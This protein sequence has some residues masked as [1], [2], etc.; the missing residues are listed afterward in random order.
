MSAISMTKEERIAALERF[1]YTRREASFLCIAALQGGYFMRRQFCTFLDKEMGGTAAS[2]V[3]KLLTRKHG[4]AVTAFN[5]TKIY[6]LGS[7]PFYA[8][9]GEGDNRNRRERS[10]PG[11]KSRLIGLDFVL[12]HPDYRYLATEG[13][14]LDYFV[15]TLGVPMGVLPNKR[16][17][18]RTGA[19]ATTRYFVDKYPIFLDADG[20]SSFCFVDESA[21]T[22]SGFETYLGQYGGFFRSLGR[23]RVIYVADAPSL[24]EA[25]ERVFAR[26]LTKSGSALIDPLVQQM[27]EHFEA[28]SL[29]ESGDHSSFN[30]E[31]LIRLRNERKQFSS[32]DHGVLYQC[33]KAG[34]RQAV[35]DIV[36]PRTSV[37]K[38]PAAQFRAYAVDQD[39]R[40]LGDNIR[41]PGC[42]QACREKETQAK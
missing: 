1:G 24:F 13:E 5:Q 27:L 28:L 6:H 41:E 15:G 16:Y 38:P 17:T 29:F 20:V 34:G 14:K 36:A 8:A 21:V 37:A 26:F 10:V 3:D 2:L 30:R 7:R 11:M 19:S 39:Y 35:L 4:S 9:L 31:K 33:W 18:A 23:F 42:R 32:P 12:A 25:A 22:I 40:F